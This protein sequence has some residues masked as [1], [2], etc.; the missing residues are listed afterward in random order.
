MIPSLASLAN[1]ALLILRVVYGIIFVA[2]G[3]PKFKDLKQNAQNFEMMGFRPGAFWGTIVASVEFFGGLCLIFGFL[4]QLA[5]ILLAVNMLVATC[6][7][8]RNKQQL[9]GGYELD[10]M[11]LSAGLLL[12]TLGGGVY[13]LDNYWAINLY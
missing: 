11:L 2:H 10:L 8:I 7:K 4:T 3:W 6:W 13:S 9:V 1:W 12:A 5:A